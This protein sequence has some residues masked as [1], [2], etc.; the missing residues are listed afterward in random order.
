MN[1]QFACTTVVSGPYSV[2]LRR[3]ANSV[4]THL[5]NLDNLDRNPID[6]I[7]AHFQTDRSDWGSKSDRSVY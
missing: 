6:Q 4:W 7:G 1:L 3:H 5:D 2:R